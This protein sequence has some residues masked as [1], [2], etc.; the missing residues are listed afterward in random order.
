[1]NF[2]S[3]AYFILFV[4]SST[5]KQFNILPVFMVADDNINYLRKFVMLNSRDDW[6]LIH[7]LH[8]LKSCSVK[9]LIK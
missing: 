3:P 9:K 8:V 6:I 1:M 4:D 7:I 5:E 2:S